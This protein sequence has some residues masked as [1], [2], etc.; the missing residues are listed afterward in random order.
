MV[1]SA[2]YKADIAIGRPALIGET[3]WEFKIQLIV[4][5]ETSWPTKPE[6]NTES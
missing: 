1:D 3:G 5:I 6:T 4:G 2:F